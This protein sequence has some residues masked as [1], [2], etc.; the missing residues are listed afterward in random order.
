MIRHWLKDPLAPSMATF[1]GLVAAGFLAITSATRTVR[2]T[3]LV[4]FQVPAVISGGLGGLALIVLGAGLANAQIGRR[5]AAQERLSS[6]AVLGEA[7]AVADLL[8]RRTR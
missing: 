4:A 6:E 8:E 3:V 2:G 7:L 5:L 1:L